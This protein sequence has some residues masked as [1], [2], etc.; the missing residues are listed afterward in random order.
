MDMQVSDV[1]LPP[2]LR[3]IGIERPEHALLVAPCSYRD[4]T[5]PIM[6]LPVANT[7]KTEFIC[8]TVERIEFFRRDGRQ[9][10]ADD[11]RLSMVRAVGLDELGGEAPILAFQAI[12]LWREVYVGQKVHLYGEYST[13]DNDPI[14]RFYDALLIA[15]EQVGQVI[16][17]TKAKQAR[18][19]MSAKRSGGC[20]V[21][22]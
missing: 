19:F 15:D 7:G 17:F 14:K 18:G 8:L 4:C 20:A 9:C 13:N 3:R 12:D 1:Q 11:N 10:S 22:R 2:G 16:P 21:S 5:D 6:I